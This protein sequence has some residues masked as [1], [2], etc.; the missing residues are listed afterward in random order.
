[1][2]K[3][4]WA[5]SQPRNYTHCCFSDNENE[6]SMVD[7]PQMKLQTYNLMSPQPFVS[8]PGDAKKEGAGGGGTES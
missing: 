1:M 4:L 8:I 3:L 6:N 5:V 7:F 2:A